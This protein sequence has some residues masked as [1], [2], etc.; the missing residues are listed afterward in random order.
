MILCEQSNS[1]TAELAWTPL[2][3]SSIFHFQ[4]SVSSGLI[5][6]LLQHTKQSPT[7]LQLL[8]PC[9]CRPP[10]DFRRKTTCSS[11]T[12]WQGHAVSLQDWVILSDLIE[13]SCSVAYHS[14]VICYV[15]TGLKRWNLVMT[16]TIW[17]KCFLEFSVG[18][19]M[20]HIMLTSYCDAPLHH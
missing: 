15:M 12:L 16:R 13:A 3:E 7:L 8:F 10:S 4:S 14:P 1:A 2:I 20:L 17:Y 18:F 5:Q 9:C 19:F 11:E 6:P